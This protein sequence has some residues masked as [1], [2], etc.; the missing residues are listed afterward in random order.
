MRS[1]RLKNTLLLLLAALL[2]W[3]TLLF[4]GLPLPA[5]FLLWLLLCA[6]LLRAGPP[7]ALLAAC[8]IAIFSL[9][10]NVFIDMTGLERGIYYR[11]HE[12]MKSSRADFGET[13]RPNTEFRMEAKFGDIE[14]REKA[15]IREPHEI[16]YRTDSLGFRNPA[17]YQAQD[18]VLVGDSF[19]AGANDSESCLISA[20]LRQDHRLDTYN[21]GFPGDMNDYV[22][23]VNAFRRAKGNDFKLAL[24]V[25][26]GN[27]FRPFSNAPAADDDLLD[28]YYN[29]FKQSSLWRYTR[30]LYLR[31][32][33]KSKDRGQKALV[34]PIGNLPMAF[35]SSEPPLATH[36]TPYAETSLRFADA[37]QLLKPNLVQIFFIP[38]K[39][40]VYARWI[41]GGGADSL[42]NAQW[43]Y[44]A[45]VA[46]QANI[47]AFD[48][49]PALTQEAERLLP[50]GQYVYWR[51]DTHWNCHGMRAAAVPVAQQL[52]L[53]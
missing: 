4:Y 1:A 5:L 17:N 33:G 16:A 15:G 51:D 36:R 13:F 3:H 38:T 21:L 9:L 53:R 45:E 7:T 30:W 32:S 46:R 6:W 14:A 23:R 47:P 37:L 20:W 29:Y 24:F 25:F 27:D 28:G 41:D 11:P 35:L 43:D 18:F 12:L 49:T 42:S 52:R 22:R 40:R 8:V 50:A 34:R 48:L 31:G 39:Y 44:L 26:E 2:L 19:L 10:L